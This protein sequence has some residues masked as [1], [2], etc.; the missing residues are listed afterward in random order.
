MKF[1]FNKRRQKILLAA[2]V[3]LLISAWFG[4][5]KFLRTEPEPKWASETERF[6]YGSIGA[7]FSRGM[8]YWIWAVLPRVFPDL[9]PGPGGYKAFGVVWEEGHEM[10]VGFT[11]Q[12]IGFPRVANNCAT[13][14]V[15]TWRSKDEETPHIVPTAP[16][17]TVN[18]QAMLR[19]LTSCAKD[20]RFNSGVLLT[21]IQREAKLSFIDKQLYRFVLI[22]LT[23]SALQRQ[24]GQLAWMNRPH[25]PSWGPGRT[26]PMNLTKY[27]MTSQPVDETVG[28][29]DM[30]SV[31]NLQARQHT[32][33]LLNW[34]GETPAVRSVM[35]DSALGIGAAPDSRSKL[36]YP[37]D[38]L[39]WQ[40][41]RRAWFL[42]RM[43]S[44]ENFLST[45]A[46]PKFPFAI[47]TAL[48][49]KGKP[50]YEKYCGEC[51]DIG[52]PKTCKVVPLA[53]IGT[54]TNRLSTWTQAAADQANA[55]VKGLGI[56]RPDL[57]Q[58]NG[59]VSAPLDGIWMRAPYL[60]NGSVPTLRDLL[61]P[62]EKRPKMFYRGYDVFDPVNVG[63]ISSGAAAEQKGWRVDTSV[64]GEGNQGHN[65]GHDL[66][67]EE[68]NALVEYLKTL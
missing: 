62:V 33:D 2:F 7:E 29:S 47:D 39:D 30:P 32:N 13:C 41:G 50:I 4:W 52:A 9:M 48:A 57:I 10:P 16:A 1:K 5:Y 65:Y 28:Q 56:K 54:D 12:V 38:W 14:H 35:I 24:D 22:P 61:E 31:W 20:S 26:D 64:R 66:S 44:L 55:A 21:E 60:H 40:L 27:F 17:N 36:T 59:Y 11:K 42:R 23:R 19:F 6:K 37:L 43:E 45:N 68:K 25:I 46:P 8:P 51:H 3:L 67:A 53:E 58:N 34:C 63:F 18:V 49:A 15:G